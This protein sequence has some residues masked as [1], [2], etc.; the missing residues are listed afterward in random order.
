MF[1]IYRPD[2]RPPLVKAAA[3]RISIGHMVDTGGAVF[4][5]DECGKSSGLTIEH[6]PEC[7][8]GRILEEWSSQW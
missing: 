4:R 2:L 7:E 3:E 1:G 6:T 5:C 8:T